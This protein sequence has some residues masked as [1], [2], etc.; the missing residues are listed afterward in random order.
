MKNAIQLTLLLIIPLITSC[1]KY[2]MPRMQ[3]GKTITTERDIDTNY[4]S[5]VAE[6]VF[7][8]IIVEGQDYDIQ[9]VCPENKLPYIETSVINGELII[10]ENNNRVSGNGPMQVFVNKTVL[11]HLRNDGSGKIS[12]KSLSATSINI[13]N[14]G[15]GNIKLGVVSEES[16]HIFNDGS[17]TIELEG[18]T[19]DI[20]I[21]NRGSGNI[22]LL[23]LIANSGE[24]DNEGSGNVFINVSDLLKVRIDGSGNVLYMG[25]PSL[26][27]NINGSGVVRPY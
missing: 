13:E 8:I 6:G 15:S 7:D 21:D 10:T 2:D 5:L 11:S 26:Q 23:T 14:V 27:V 20:L 16:V 22:D 17:G 9:I 24:V 12:G 18:E 1:T 19:T 25:N 4:T 3:G